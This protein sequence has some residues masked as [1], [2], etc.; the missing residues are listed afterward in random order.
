MTGVSGLDTHAWCR[1]LPH[2]I[3]GLQWL[4][5]AD[6]LYT[7]TIDPA[8]LV[9][10]LLPGLFLRGV[11]PIGI[12]EVCRRIIAKAVFGVLQHYHLLV[13]SKFVP[14][15]KVV[16]RELPMPC[17]KPLFSWNRSAPY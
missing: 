1:S 12:G 9:D 14:A 6:G 3:S 16:V 13:L 4:L 10:L 7:V 17:A 8:N 11:R 2:E 15:M 5:L